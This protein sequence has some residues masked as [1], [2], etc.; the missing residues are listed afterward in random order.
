MT[1]SDD[2]RIY[3]NLGDDY[4]G[5]N[6]SYQLYLV[7]DY[8]TK[9]IYTGQ[10]YYMKPSYLYFKD[11]VTP[12]LN[13]YQWIKDFEVGYKHWTGIYEFTVRVE[14]GN[15]QTYTSPTITNTT[16]IPTVDYNRIL[17]ILPKNAGS[18][19]FFGWLSP[20]ATDI[21][22]GIKSRYITN[23]SSLHSDTSGHSKYQWSAGNLLSY[24]VG[25]CEA[26][27]K[28]T[29]GIY[30]KIAEYNTDE[31]PRFYLIWVTR[32]NDYMCRPFCKRSDLTESVS[33]TYITTVNDVNTPYLKDIKFKWK[34]NSDWLTY[35]EY[36][37]YESLLISPVVYL[38]DTQL[39]KRYLVNV[40]DNIWTEK[41]DNNTKKPFN[42]TVNIEL[43]QSSNIT[44]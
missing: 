8:E 14:F 40:T 37:V 7:T 2:L 41:N 5:Q 24:S 15:G 38:Y 22:T 25:M 30:T 16:E 27:W 44:Y 23:I 36:P 33:N 42:M 3:Y 6:V 29:D 18:E 17:S 13:D 19:F 9:H 31:D 35:E 32:D 34:L 12:Y 4:I 21:Y 11:I 20:A 43:S 28:Y 10:I 1:L 26:I 39:N